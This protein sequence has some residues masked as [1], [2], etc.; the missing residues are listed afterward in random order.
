MCVQN[1]NCTAH[2]KNGK[3]SNILSTLPKS[4]HWFDDYQFRWMR[5]SRNKGFTRYHFGLSDHRNP[6]SAFICKNHGCPPKRC[7]K[8]SSY[9]RQL[10]PFTNL[11]SRDS[12]RSL[13]LSPLFLQQWIFKPTWTLY[14]E[15]HTRTS[16][17]HTAPDPQLY[18]GRISYRSCDVPSRSRKHSPSTM[19]RTNNQQDSTAEQVTFDPLSQYSLSRTSFFH[20]FIKHCL[21]TVSQISTFLT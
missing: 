11:C 12:N 19:N 21:T 3:Q 18:K 9:D 20:T 17:T 1:P 8:S 14:L 15:F 6:L 16:S 5:V 13:T 7:L 10:T 2:R 4:W